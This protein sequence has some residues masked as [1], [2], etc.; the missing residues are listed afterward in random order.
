MTRGNI[1]WAWIA[2]VA[3]ALSCGDDGSSPP[4]DGSTGDVTGS[5]TTTAGTD[6]DAATTTGAATTAASSG[7]A[8]GSS[9]TS[10]DSGSTDAD[11]TTDDGG[12]TEAAGCDNEILDG[13]ETDIDCGGSCPACPLG[14]A[15]NSSDDCADGDCDSGSCLGPAPGC[16]LDDVQMSPGSGWSDSYSVDG[17]CY[18]DTT[19]DHNI[20]DI[21]VDTPYGTFTVYEIC[22]AIGP[23]PGAGGHP[24]YNDIQCGHGPAN[25]AGDEDWCPGRVDQGEAGCCTAGPTWDLSVLAE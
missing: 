2:S 14:G 15:C 25:D 9:T 10:A 19:F 12:E 21:E 6:S 24:V 23:G 11:T 4:Q 20:G 5:N 8:E 16:N 3:L 7:A 22:D 13:D 18:C 17:R 1:Y